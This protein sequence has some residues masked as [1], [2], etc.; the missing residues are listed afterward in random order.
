MINA[1][2]ETL[3]EKSSFKQAVVKRRCIVPS[4]GFYEW[5]KTVNGKQAHRIKTTD[6]EVFAMAGLWDRW[7]DKDGQMTF[8]FTIITQQ[9]NKKIGEIH[10]RM[11]AIL[12]KEQELLWLS[13]DIPPEELVEMIEP[14]PEDLIEITRVSNRVNKVS[15]NDSSLIKE[16][17]DNQEGP[18]TLF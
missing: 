17:E 4:D 16:Y 2:I 13:N 12:T 10:D 3:F 18:L 9:S 7:S 8:S 1:R 6:S 14:Y 15:N 5:K 11:P